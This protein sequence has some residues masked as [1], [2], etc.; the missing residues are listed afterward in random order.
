MQRLAED[1][2]TYLQTLGIGTVGTNIFAGNMP[3][4][5]VRC[6]GVYANGGSGALDNA[7]CLLPTIQLLVRDE[8]AN[9]ISVANLTDY[10]FSLL[11]GKWNILNRFQG[12]LTA[13][14]P[15]GAN[16]RDDAGNWMFP[17][18]FQG[19]FVQTTF[20]SPSTL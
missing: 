10:V 8:Y 18:N 9:R 4:S 6:I 19:M 1:V 16:Y 13:L 20:S 11:D 17:L 7:P 2:A 15:P 12:R 14:A 5:P 3:S